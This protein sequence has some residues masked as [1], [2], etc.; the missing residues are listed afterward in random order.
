MLHALNVRLISMAA[1][2]LA[3]S[4]SVTRAHHVGGVGNSQGA[5]PI[6]TIS[7]STLQQ[8]LSVAGI[9]VDYQRLKGLSN[10]TLIE[11]AEHAD[12]E[13]AGH[14]DVHDLRSVQS[15]ALTYSYGV[16]NDLMLKVKKAKPHSNEG[17]AEE[18]AQRAPQGLAW[19]LAND[20]VPG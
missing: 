1:I 12:D 3:L 14:Q 17:S 4:C 10:Q 16:T 15:Y 13:A 18:H 11:A 9:S 2:T 20:A 6:N 5:G 7:A 19:R 8:G